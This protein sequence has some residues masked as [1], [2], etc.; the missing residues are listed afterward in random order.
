MSNVGGAGMGMPVAAAAYY[1]RDQKNVLTPPGEPAF[2]GGFSQQAYPPQPYANY[3]QSSGYAG[4]STSQG[5]GGYDA[6]YGATQTAQI[7]QTRPAAPSTAGHTSSTSVG[8]LGLYNPYLHG[9]SPEPSVSGHT[10]TLSHTTSSSGAGSPGPVGAGGKGGLTVAN[11]DEGSTAQST[12]A[13]GASAATHRTSAVVVHEDGGRVEVRAKNGGPGN[14]EG[15]EEAGPSEIP[16][17]YD[18]IMRDR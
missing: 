14:V 6:A 10:G 8:N 12:S 13:A 9:P 17:T 5:Y 11:P 16:P 15:E 4:A 3:G 18:S 1:G 2:T 7:P